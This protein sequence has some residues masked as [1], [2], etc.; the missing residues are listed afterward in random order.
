MSELREFTIGS[1]VACTDGECGERQRLIIDPVARALTHLAVEPR[2]QRGAGRLVPVDLVTLTG[3]EIRLSCT[4]SDFAALEQAEVTET[5]PD[6]SVDWGYVQRQMGAPYGGGGPIF[7]PYTPP[8]GPRSIT[9]DVV[10][11][12]EEEVRGGDEVHATDGSV[13]ALRGLLTNPA[14][15]V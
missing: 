9:H 10:A 5:L 6:S 4:L 14:I 2:H 15:I 11:T 12:G 7:D 1:D 3:D 8:A 13:G